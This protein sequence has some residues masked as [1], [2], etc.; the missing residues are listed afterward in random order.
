MEIIAGLDE[1]EEKSQQPPTKDSSTDTHPA[2]LVGLDDIFDI[3]VTPHGLV[4]HL[5][6]FRQ[7]L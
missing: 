5:E 1:G 7:D 6:P 3:G 4:Q 2:Q